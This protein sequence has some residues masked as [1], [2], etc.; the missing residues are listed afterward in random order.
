MAEVATDPQAGKE[1]IRIGLRRLIKELRAF[2][3]TLADL[4]LDHGMQLEDIESEL[5]Q[6]DESEDEEAGQRIEKL[7]AE[8]EEIKERLDAEL[9][10]VGTQRQGVVDLIKELQAEM[11]GLRLEQE[12]EAGSEDETAVD[13]D[14]SAGEA[15]AEAEPI[16]LAGEPY[17]G[18]ALPIEELRPQLKEIWVVEFETSF[19]GFTIE[20]Y[21]ELSP[22][23]AVRFLE[24][25]RDGFYD[26][27]HI[28]RIAPGW[29]VQWGDLFDRTSAAEAGAPPEVY[30]Q[31]AER[32]AM[33]VSLK[34]DP[35][36]FPSG[37]WTV[38]FAKRGPDTATGQPFINLADNDA[39]LAPQGFAPFGYVTEGREAIEGLIEAFSP[40]MQ[41][42]RADL[43][44]DMEEAGASPENVIEMALKN[45]LRWGRYVYQYW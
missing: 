34:D 28:H 40:V 6:L 9:E 16:A 32:S 10:E 22:V 7:E 27:M 20:A 5:E 1:Q 36:T 21:P 43:R 44:A 12:L 39:V 4:E 19:G 42:C 8:L 41:K 45:D 38:D 18:P 23:H 37:R 3:N 24:L 14:S 29:V 2:N 30:P 25:V 11:R 33:A 35:L 26:D 17:A 13:S 15:G 31:Y